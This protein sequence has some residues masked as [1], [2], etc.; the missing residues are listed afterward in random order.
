MNSL[1]HR[2][3]F[4]FI[5]AFLCVKSDSYAQQ[6]RGTSGKSKDFASL[7]ER[8]QS[9]SGVGLRLI[10]L[11]APGVP[12]AMIANTDE[13]APL[14]SANSLNDGNTIN[15]I[16]KTWLGSLA[17]SMLGVSENAELS[18]GVTTKVGDVWLSTFQMSFQT[19]PVRERFIHL[20]I[21]ALNGK[22]MMIRN[23]LPILEPNTLSPT[24]T[25]DEILHAVRDNLGSLVKT[26]KEPSLVL[27]DDRASHSLRLCFELTAGSSS[28]DE[29]WR[30]T[31]DA[32]T[33]DLIEKKN[34]LHS[35][36]LKVAY[37]EADTS[38]SAPSSLQRA[39][40][41]AN[42][43]FAP[44]G[45]VFGTITA[46][47]RL[48]TPFDTPVSVGL[49]YTQL[50]VNG[51]TTYT[52][53]LGNW[54]VP[55][56][57]FPALVQTAFSGKYH[58][59]QRQDGINNV[60][61]Q[62]FNSGPISIEWN[63]L[64]SDESERDAYY[65]IA[66][67]H[68]HA[69]KIDP[70]LSLL[71]QPLGVLV[72][73][74][75]SCNAF[76]DPIGRTF[77]FFNASTSCSNTAQIADVV[78]HEFGHRI[79]HARYSQA[80][81]STD[82]N[83]VDG[84]LNEG[85]ADLNSSF[86]RDDARIGVNF[87]GNNTRTLRNCNNTARFPDDINGDIHVNG[88]IISG[89]FW[90]LRKTMGLK[91]T[92]KL[93]HM[94]GYQR[95]DG[96][97][98]IDAA[99]LQEA[100][101]NTLLATLITDDDDNNLANATPHTSQIVAAFDKHNIGLSGLIDLAPI[102][103]ADQDSSA[104]NYPLTV[105][106]KYNA[107]IGSLDQNSL[108]I[109]YKHINESDYHTTALTLSH[110][111]LFSGIIPKMP[112]GSIVQYY[113]SGATTINT[114]SIRTVPFADEPLTFLVGFKQKIFD[115]A[116]TESGWQKGSA[117]DNATTGRWTR[118]KPIGNFYTDAPTFFVQ[119]DTDHSLFGTMCFITGN[120]NTTDPSKDDVDGGVTTLITP[121][122]DLS[123]MNEPVVRYWYYFSNNTGNNPGLPQWIVKLTLDDG[124]HWKTIQQTP[125]ATDGWTQFLYRIRD[126]GV[127]SDKVRVEFLASDN[128]GSL[129]E[130]GVDDF[131]IL[132][133][134]E[135]SNISVHSDKTDMLS[136][137]V[138]SQPTLR[139]SQVR[140]SFSLPNP[141]HAEIILRDLFGNVVQQI[142][143]GNYEV[144]EHTLSFSPTANLAS[145]IY[146]LELRTSEGIKRVKI[147]IL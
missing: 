118:G 67:A 52:D 69:K 91:E 2:L 3:T 132:N 59:I 14:I 82:S 49:P 40:H 21:G 133:A 138:S 11:S 141:L 80:V 121:L 131:E 22:V 143:N 117:T 130:A 139:N 30:M 76:Y 9:L 33:G 37:S 110:D 106:A 87:Y 116:E 112:I 56:T 27:V 83:M 12:G 114:S 41:Q 5:L 72:N 90:D 57:T 48:R 36:C 8:V 47:V 45:S 53:S 74:N 58:T 107:P 66:F 113:V 109:H 77:T 129:V 46:Q 120:L 101:T 63:N 55:N 10:R 140:I 146:L 124:L 104:E 102:P 108:L 43:F 17:T 126:Y 50:S 15:L 78:Y 18:N 119:Q 145:G 134:P 31:Y 100:F 6:I 115:N 32:T 147:A 62:S 20:N 29:L 128:I 93:F 23:N 135:I 103:I 94:M 44:L 89:A 81:G 4:A 38:N 19:I 122:Y 99:S 70:T 28:H 39:N 123:S 137:S 13:A 95:P 54:S 98:G 127:P 1:F 51:I 35:D 65:S 7:A 75:S 68:D 34:L 16:A 64:N 125:A 85:F 73:Y 26:I 136:L 97:G 142:G 71:D 25:T 88:E 79:N 105:I 84:S 61:S 24:M 96:P 60:I 42:N 86:I 144:G 92:E 111:S